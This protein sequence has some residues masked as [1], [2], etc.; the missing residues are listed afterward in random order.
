[1][2]YKLGKHQISFHAGTL[3]ILEKFTQH[4]KFQLEAGGII[5]GKLIGDGIEVMRLS[6]P[7]TLDKSSRYRFVRHKT[8]AQIIV[9]YEFYNS[10]GEMVY[11]GE[12]HTHPEIHPNPSCI[13]RSMIKRQYRSKDRRTDV[14][15]LVIQGIESRYVGLIE[16]GKLS[17]CEQVT[18]AQSPEGP[19]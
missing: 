4:K 16:N 18:S 19:T 2:I 6:V 11:L 14:L 3:A 13:D 1:M 10:D 17:T 12:W 7:T 9:D 15:L 5:L 8:S